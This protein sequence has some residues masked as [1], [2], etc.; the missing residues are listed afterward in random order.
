MG[1]VAE[2]GSPGGG[3]ELG[4]AQ[5]GG[6]GTPAKRAV[7]AAATCVHQHCLPSCCPPSH[8]PLPASSPPRS[9]CCC[10]YLQKR[11]LNSSKGPAVW[12][13]RAQT[14][15][16]EYAAVMRQ[17]LEAT[18]NLHI[19]E[20]EHSQELLASGVEGGRG[21]ARAAQRSVLQQ[22][23][24][25]GA[26]VSAA[27]AKGKRRQR[28]RC[29]TGGRRWP[30]LPCL[31]PSLLLPAGMV[32]SVEV[33]PND[34]I[35]GVTT[36]WGVTFRCRAAVLTTGTFMNGQ[37]NM[38]RGWQGRWETRRAGHAHA[39]VPPA[40]HPL[41][42]QLVGPACRPLAP[43]CPACLP[44]ACPIPPSPSPCPPHTHPH[45]HTRYGWGACRCRRGAP[46]R[47]PPPA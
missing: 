45:Q 5:R 15:K 29:S 23:R 25:P 16:L 21:Q 20:G 39:R 33:G 1:G 17:V 43:S 19:R 28:R 18:P 40:G 46:A 31:P 44:S 32:T 2:W 47:R 3:L 13:L 11:V 12:A 6:G 41:P 42:A 14:D 27:A 36:Y 34:D 10:S 8:S 30:S 35:C 24:R 26:A 37:V 38:D 4:G 22:V 9:P 7:C